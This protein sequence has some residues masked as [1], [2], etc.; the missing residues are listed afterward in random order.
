MSRR[1]ISWEEL[2][3]L[4]CE[5]QRRKMVERILAKGD[6]VRYAQLDLFNNELFDKLGQVL[7]Q[8][9]KNTYAVDFEGIGQRAVDECCLM[10]EGINGANSW[11]EKQGKTC[12]VSEK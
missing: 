5:I 11:L 9:G 8:T 7:H 1:S 10:K 4:N 2:K 12:K 3:I 6:V